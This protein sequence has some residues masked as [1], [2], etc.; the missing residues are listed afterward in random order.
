MRK[1]G[2][3]TCGFGTHKKNR[4]GGSQGGK[5]KAGRFKHKKTWVLTFEPNYYGKRGFKVPVKAKKEVNTITLRN[6]DV[7]AKKLNKT[8]INLSELGFDKVLSTGV[9]T[10]PLTITAKKI[11]GKAKEKIESSGG[12]AIENV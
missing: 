9:L 1:R 7:L 12:K 8:E 6:I 11:V 2:R 3:R 10:Q 5:G 4:G